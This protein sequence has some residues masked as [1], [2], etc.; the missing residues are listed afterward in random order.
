MKGRILKFKLTFLFYLVKMIFFCC[1][2]SV[3]FGMAFLH[4][5][6]RLKRALRANFA[7]KLMC[8][9]CEKVMGN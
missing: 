8:T 1:M 4:Y 6:V 3:I 7:V 5:F 2:S 9:R